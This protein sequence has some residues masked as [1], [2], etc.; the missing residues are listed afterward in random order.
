MLSEEARTIRPLGFLST[1]TDGVE[2]LLEFAA[3]SL[4]R[5]L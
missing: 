1:A 4:G 3:Y 2:L 5:P